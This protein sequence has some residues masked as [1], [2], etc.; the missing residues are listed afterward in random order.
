MEIQ[1]SFF[2]PTKLVFQEGGLSEL[3]QITQSYGSKV[4]LVTYGRAGGRLGF[5]DEAADAL[6]RAGLDVTV[7]DEALPNPTVECVAE[8]A[9]LARLH[10][11]EVVI[12]LGGGSA[13]DTAKGIAV[14][15]T[16][17]G[18]INDYVIGG[19]IGSEGITASTLPIIAVPT[20]AGTGSEATWGAVIS[21]T[22]KK[23]KNV[24]ISP[25]LYPKVALVDV[26]LMRSLPPHLTASI[27]MDGLTQSIEGFVSPK[28]SVM[29][30]VLALYSIQLIAKSLEG[31][32]RQGDDLHLRAKVAL[33]STLSGIVISHAG[34]GAVHAIS[35][36]LGG[37]YGVPHGLGNAILL[38]DVVTYNLS[39][40]PAKFAEVARALGED[41]SGLSDA[42]AGKQ[43]VNAVRRLQSAVGI[44]PS[45][46]R[47]GFEISNIPDLARRALKHPDMTCN[48]RSLSVEEL[49][50]ILRRVL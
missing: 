25:Y 36:V 29:T 38:P 39:A 43:C 8:G 37:E 45:L 14:A 42:E 50:D 11:T 28:A 18:N 31:V 27:G 49:A 26:N 40:N 12:G 24:L 48:P 3:P 16:H 4:M 35:M 15:S 7:Y 17:E 23:Q 10:Q 2:A 30:D 13:I 44:E 5:V 34:V 47:Y 46:R 33:G 41:V 6:S 9:K 1:F 20:A 22:E 21:D 19:S 32:V